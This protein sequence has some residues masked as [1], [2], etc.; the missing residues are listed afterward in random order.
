MKNK[1]CFL[2]SNKKKAEDF[3][4]FG[5]GV[6][7]FHTDIEE[8]LSPEV[9]T[10]VLYKA[11]DTGL[12]N[13]LVEDTSLEVE[14]ADFYGTQIKHVYD[15][16]KDDESFNGKK[17]I[18]RVSICMRKDDFF[19]ISTGVLEG[20]LKYPA[21]DTGYHFD[22]IFAV[23]TKEGYRQFELFSHEEKM[24]IGPRFQAI[25]KLVHALETNDY[26]QLRK[27]AVLDVKEWEGEYQIENNKNPIK[28]YKLA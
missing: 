21:L 9:E 20:I 12:N 18:W 17:A 26:S 27:I 1:V 4:H 2:T 8:V 23:E 14:G 25:K 22:R 24:E 13:I 10:V 28:K 11:K 7:E 3:T 19:Y 6:K 5:L 15:E 16:V